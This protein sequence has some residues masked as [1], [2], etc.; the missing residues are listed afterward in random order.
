MHQLRDLLCVKTTAM[1][2]AYLAGLADRIFKAAKCGKNWAV[3]KIF[4]ILGEDK[5]K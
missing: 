3:D 1:G 2:A 5:E 4:S